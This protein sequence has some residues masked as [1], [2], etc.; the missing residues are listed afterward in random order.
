MPSKKDG[1][2]KRK[3]GRPPVQKVFSPAE[4]QAKARAGIKRTMER[5]VDFDNIDVEEFI[6]FAGGITHRN[7]F[8]KE[9]REEISLKLDLLYHQYV[10]EKQDAEDALM[11]PY[12]EPLK[13]LSLE[14]GQASGWTMMS[15]A[16]WNEEHGLR[17][18][19][20][21][22]KPGPKKKKPKSIFDVPMQ[23]DNVELP[24][25]EELE[26]QWME[27]EIARREQEPK[28]FVGK[29][30][31]DPLTEAMRPKASTQ[32]FWT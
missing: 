4:L 6:E 13:A 25:Y 32:D 26:R 28:P 31:R 19:G 23:K 18:D 30:L 2:P 7:K 29:R 15:P 8:T 21:G 1:S 5:R 27:Q 20:K 17:K 14:Q 10:I 11:E 22:L 24:D 3:R 12:I 9:E 16:K